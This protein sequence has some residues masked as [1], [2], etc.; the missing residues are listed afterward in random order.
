MRVI[1]KMQAVKGFSLKAR[2]G[3]IGALKQIY[4]DDRNWVVRYL[5]VH[6]GS[7]L[8]G[9]EVLISPRS[10]IQ[11]DE[12]SKRLVVA[13]TR[14]QITH[15][16][17]LNSETPVSRQYEEALHRYYEWEPYW[18]NDPALGPILTADAIEPALENRE[19]P[20]P[21]L[22]LRSSDE[23]SGH[24]VHARD[25]EIGHVEDFLI[26]DESWAVRY[27]EV[28]TRSWVPGKRV[29][30]AP[31]WIDAIDWL[32]GELCV[33]LERAAIQKAP[34]Y[35]PSLLVDRDYEARLFAHYGE[36]AHA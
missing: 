15:S 7:W 35:D 20:R 21:E 25:G 6:T 9:R 34:E 18:L 33:R 13:L 11:V 29:L 5:V 19:Q 4:F 2:D 32:T 36:D 24:R 16:P 31:T 10:V 8:M 1:R 28:H 3:E 22:H 17:A 23:L 26:D 27:L 12:A 14:Q 30:L